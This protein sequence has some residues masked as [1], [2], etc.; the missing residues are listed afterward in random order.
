MTDMAIN[1]LAA[2]EA[3]L[4]NHKRKRNAKR[5]IFLCWHSS[6]VPGLKHSCDANEAVAPDKIS[7]LR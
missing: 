4:D 6:C 7:V 1:G 5:L 2:L 3:Q